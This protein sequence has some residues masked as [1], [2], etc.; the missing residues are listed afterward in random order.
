[1]ARGQHVPALYASDVHC[2]NEIERF[3]CNHSKMLNEKVTFD[4]LRV[5]RAIATHG[6]FA[7]AGRALGRTTSAVS[8]AVKTL[9]DALGVAL[10]DR[11][12]HGA[13]WTADGKLVRAEAR[14][15][16]AEADR[17]QHLADGLRAGY[18]ARLS[19]VIDGLLPQ[20]PVMRA[21]RRFAEAGLPTR[22]RVA[23]EYL[24]GVHTRF[25]AGADVMVALDHTPQPGTAA[26][27][28][29]PVELVLLAHHAHPLAADDAVDRAALG[30][31]VELIVEDSGLKR[32]GGPGRLA[33]G[34]AQV[35]RVSDFHAKR[36]ALLEGV[37]FGWMPTHLVQAD[38]RRGALVQLAF[39]E[40]AVA[41]FVPHLVTRTTPAP[42]PAAQRFVALLREEL[43]AD[44]LGPA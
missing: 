34:A 22:L 19:V 43:A 42:G 41:S 1:M 44:G 40:G 12:G 8:Y 24:T 38:V 29:A 4:Q 14:R 25:A 39:A 17:L 3:F 31:H 13:A 26:V 37:G 27:A 33:L 6:T 21:A 23:I 2:V 35:F 30:L 10:F 36:E 18:E 7:G 11:S 32:D 16:L 5:V 20:R 28:L 15:L 9:E